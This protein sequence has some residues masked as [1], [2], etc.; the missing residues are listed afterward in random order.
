MFASDIA[1]R[2]ELPWQSHRALIF[3]SV[4]LF[5]QDGNGKW[6]NRMICSSSRRTSKLGTPKPSTSQGN[7]AKRFLE[8]QRLRKQ[9]RE[10][11]RLAVT[12]LKQDAP[13][14]RTDGIGRR[15]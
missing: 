8:W 3:R 1:Q 12:A 11:E 4:A 14:A 6:V 9:V 2:P 13:G 5:H 7:L 15:R 10:L